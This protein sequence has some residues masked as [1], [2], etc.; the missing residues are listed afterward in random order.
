M[1]GVRECLLG[2]SYFYHR[3][4]IKMSK[5]WSP[6]EIE[7]YQD[8]RFRQLTRRYGDE[9]TQKDDYRRDLRRYTRWDVPVIART[10]RTGGTSGQPLRFTADRFARRQKER[11]YLLISGL[12]WDTRRTT[13]ES[14]T[15][16]ISSRECFPTTASRMYG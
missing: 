4:L 12:R 11:A 1:T 3:Q 15:A 5:G 10:V 7:H 13:S 8:T 9:I 14:G 16:A 6:S 2:P